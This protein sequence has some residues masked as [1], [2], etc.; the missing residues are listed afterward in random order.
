[1]FTLA[2][3]G[4]FLERV[5][6]VPARSTD[7]LSAALLVITEVTLSAAGIWLIV[8]CAR[9]LLAGRASAFSI[10]RVEITSRVR[11]P[12]APAPAAAP[13]GESRPESPSPPEALPQPSALPA[14]MPPVPPAMLAAPEGAG[15]PAV[16]EAAAPSPAAELEPP[17][18][19]R[20]PPPLLEPT[21][22]VVAAPFTLPAVPGT[23]QTFGPTEAAGGDAPTMADASMATAIPLV[24]RAGAAQQANDSERNEAS[25]SGVVPAATRGA[26]L[27]PRVSWGDGARRA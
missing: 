5:T 17:T 1:M 4:A 12:R 20:T 18:T 22:E 6:F 16:T 25:D 7:V 15:V 11:L 23:L 26:P 24:H 2:G 10:A 19:E 14:T 3:S 8:I 9:A 27:P 13:V 21:L